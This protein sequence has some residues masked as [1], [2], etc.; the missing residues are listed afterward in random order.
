MNIKNKKSEYEDFLQEENDI[1]FSSSSKNKSDSEKTLHIITKS[2]NK[3]KWEFFDV[4]INELPTVTD[5]EIDKLMALTNKA[6]SKGTLKKNPVKQNIIFYKFVLPIA[7]MFLITALCL[8][9]YDTSPNHPVY[10]GSGAS[11]ISKEKPNDIEA[12]SR[13][14]IPGYDPEHFYALIIGIDKYKHWQKLKTA[15]NDARELADVLRKEY[16]F[17]NIKVLLNEEAT[18]EKILDAI[19]LYVESLGKEDSVLIYYAGHGWMDNDTKSG[20]WVPYDAR[21]KKK[22]DYI[23][24]SQIIQDYFM[25]YKVK[26][27]VVIADSCFSGTLVGG[28][29]ERSAWTATR[30]F[31]IPSRSIM[32]SGG[33]GPVPDGAGEHSPFATQ[34]L[35]Y[36]KRPDK[37]N[38]GIQDVYFYIRDNLSNQQP[39]PIAKPLICANHQSGGEFIFCRKKMDSGM[40]VKDLPQIGKP[41]ALDKTG[42][43]SLL[44][45]INGDLFIDNVKIARVKARNTY[46]LGNYPAGEHTLKII[47]QDKKQ[48]WQENIIVAENQKIEITTGFRGANKHIQIKSEKESFSEF[49]P[50]A[51][52]GDASSQLWVANAFLNGNGVEKNDKLA[53]EFFKKA[54]IQG[55]AEAQYRL[56]RSYHYGIG[57]KQNDKLAFQWYSK[58]ST[59]ENSYGLNALGVCYDYGIGVTKDS[60][61]AI[62]M[63]K[64]SMN[65]GNLLA[66]V[67]IGLCYQKGTGVKKDYKKAVQWYRK[68]AEQG[69]ASAQ[70]NLGMCYQYRIGVNKDPKQAV[71]WYR[72]AAEQGYTNAQYSLAFCYNNGIGV[73]KDLKQ[74]ILWYRKAAEQGYAKAQNNLGFCYQYGTGVKKDSKKAVLWYHKSAKQDNIYGQYNLAFCYR[75]G[76]GVKEDPKQAILWYHKSAEQGYAKAQN[77]LGFCYQNGTGVKKNPKKAVQWYRKAAEQNNVYAQYNLALCY[78]Y[79]RGVKEDPKKAV[80]WYRKAAEQ[81][82]ASAQHSLALCYYNGLGVKEDLKKAVNWYSKAADQGI[83]ASQY[84]LALCYRKGLGVKEDPKQAVQWYR[85]AAEQGYA[86]AQYNLALCYYNG[87]GVTKDPKQAFQL[88]REA[89]KK[90]DADAQYMLG[91]C[92]QYEI[93][94]TKDP[95]KAVLWYHKS[96]EQGYADAQYMLGFCYQYEIGVKKDPKK[97]VQWYRKAAKKGNV[98]AQRN[99]GICYK[100]GTGVKKDPKQAVLWL[101]KAAKK[102]YAN[103]QYRL[104]ICYKNGTGVDKDEKKAVQWYRKAAEQG[105]ASAQNGLAWYYVENNIKLKEAEKW[106][107]QSL[108]NNPNNKYFVDTLG[109]IYYK[110]GKYYEAERKFIKALSL[111]NK[112]K[113][114]KLIISIKK[115]LAEVYIKQGKKGK[116]RKELDFILQK[117]KYKKPFTKIKKIIKK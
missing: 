99:L 44:C 70:Y 31:Y 5:S 1:V 88:Y 43:I 86:K 75:Y 30:S 19:D 2:L 65:K 58:S 69:Y 116:A 18:R 37:V 26:H 66:H 49:M 50:K 21:E 105:Y 7:A 79:G 59:Q 32:T 12:I 87:I 96:A 15:T 61:K 9:F 41:E 39:I 80:Q 13:P 71:Q 98:Y 22:F 36:L 33:L 90:G 53:F 3:Y 24:H 93:G 14:T 109:W 57:V 103:A 10:R 102:G 11:I 45:K 117:S 78:Y 100:N 101:L 62:I 27:L 60:K 56:G 46:P 6:R 111:C 38:F 8:F 64:R 112:M 20:Y 77:S 68:A 52:E 72:K 115:H 25:K 23:P 29:A 113:E 94:V 108:K 35:K 82:Y 76:F 83:A 73:T 42:S 67:N 97:A 34:L 48:I 63:Y 114:L 107:K 110:Q 81:G 55:I 74:A 91:F 89:A 92:Y 85:K 47:P 54:A 4:N 84:N 95:K 40:R 104:G 51:L 28:N 16:R 17:K 106:S